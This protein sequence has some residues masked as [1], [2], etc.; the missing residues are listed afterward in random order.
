M[1]PKL[2]PFAPRHFAILSSWFESEAELIRWGGP[3]LSFPLNADQLQAMIDEGEGDRPGRLCWMA[4]AGEMMIG[5]A[6]LVFDWQNG[7]A[8]LAR[9]AIAPQARGRGLSASM[10]RQV[11]ARAFEDPE[12]ERLE[13]NVYANNLPAIRAYRRLGFVAE[14]LRRGAT[15]VGRDR[16]DTML[17]G[18]LR[19]EWAKTE[20]REPPADQAAAH[21]S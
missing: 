11:V 4:G 16:W 19:A 10:L 21:G 9:G 3:F 17:M 13:L 18:M 1:S 2:I 6:Q 5:H 7:G 14:G 8:R 20:P 15:R 12:I